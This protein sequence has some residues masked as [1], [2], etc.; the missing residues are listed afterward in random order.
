MK[1]QRID[2]SRSARRLALGGGLLSL[3]LLCGG[4][5]QAADAPVG[6]V[7]GSNGQV[8]R[9]A[10][11]N[12]VHTIQ[13]SKENAIEQCDPGLVAK[14]EP[15]QP[16]VAQ[17]QPTPPPAPRTVRRRINLQTD[18]YFHF[19]S[20]QLTDDGKQKLGQLAQRIARSQ[21]PQVQI[22]GYTDPIGTEQYNQKL[23]EDRAQAVKQ[24]LVQQGIANDQVQVAA[25]G[26]SNPVVQCP[27][28]QGNA[29]IQ[30]LA[31]NRRSQVEF[32]AF[33]EVTPGESGGQG[34]QSPQAAPGAA[35][36]T[37][38]SSAFPQNGGNSQPQQ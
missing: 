34:Q 2:P 13:W 29:L 11:G 6:Y 14:A 5:A 21:N 18:T 9:D 15:P 28:K 16:E 31:P 33:E 30:C 37:G 35:S 26:E 20:A 23:S 36:G 4:A 10:A 7:V 12:C 32:S 8:V 1:L 19:D 22:T 25:R 17:A 24:Y 3:G 38:G 27:D